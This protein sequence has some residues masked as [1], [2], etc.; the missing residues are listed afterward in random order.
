[1]REKKHRDIYIFFYKLEQYYFCTC[2]DE[3]KDS[4][5]TG[6]VMFFRN[7]FDSDLI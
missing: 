7:R 2:I 5:L 1:M 3:Q 6:I 4:D